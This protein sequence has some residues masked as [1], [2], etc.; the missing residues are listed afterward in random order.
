M[1]CVIARAGSTAMSPV[2]I[3]VARML[4]APRRGGALIAAAPRQPPSAIC[5]SA[6]RLVLPLLPRGSSSRKRYSRGRW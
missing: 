1:R 6:R 3:D 4:A 2:L 5:R